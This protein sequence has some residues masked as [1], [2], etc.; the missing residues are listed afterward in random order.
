MKK[1]LTLMLLSL[2]L[3]NTNAQERTAKIEF[4][5]ETIV[6]NL[7]VIHDHATHGLTRNFC[8][9]QMVEYIV[10]VRCANNGKVFSFEVIVSGAIPKIHTVYRV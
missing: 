3:L 4:E 5:S 9:N 7:L 2:F 8:R 1:I 6:F 10:S